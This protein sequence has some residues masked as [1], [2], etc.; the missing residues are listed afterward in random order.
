MKRAVFALSGFVLV[1]T[2]CI[3]V[4]RTPAL[5][6]DFLGP[7]TRFWF[8][9][10]S[11]FMGPSEA[12]VAFRE[13][14]WYELGPKNWDPYKQLWEL[15]RDMPKMSDADPRA[16]AML[17]K[18]HEIWANAPTNSELDRASIRI[19]GYIVPLEQSKIGIKEFLLVPY[20]G[21]CIHTPPPPSNQIIHVM[22]RE[23]V[24]ECAQWTQHG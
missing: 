5:S 23:T 9:H 8:L 15:Q 19:V 1:V 17:K 12:G 20:F 6:R 18:V 3:V 7:V 16:I 10:R 2:L 11:T 13:I 24:W 22:S 4:V 14:R 21:A